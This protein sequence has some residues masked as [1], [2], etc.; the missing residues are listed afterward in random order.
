MADPIQ[1]VR[2]LERGLP[3]LLDQ[4][5]TLVSAESPSSDPD[6]VCACGEVLD[7]LVDSQLGVSAERVEVD[8]VTHL[9]WILGRPRVLL[10]GHL[11]TVW[12]H[13]TLQ[14]RPFE[15]RD[16]RL[17]G[18]GV[19]DMKAGLVQAV[20]AVAMLDDPTGIELLVTSDEEIGSP[21]S[22]ELIIEGARRA[23]AV[24]VF[25]GAAGDAVKTERKGLSRYTLRTAGRAAHAGLEPERGANALVDA[26]HQV[27]AAEALA[28]PELGTSVT[29]TLA[30]AGTASNVVPA[31]AT[32][33]IDVRAATY[34]EQLR[35]HQELCSW[36]ASL[37][38]VEL[39][40]EGEINRQPMDAVSTRELF[41]R[42]GRAAET[43]GV[44]PPPGVGVGGVSDANLAAE[45]GAPVIDGLGAVGGGAH[46]EDEH[47]IVER[48]PE[49]TALAAVLIGDLLADPVRRRPTL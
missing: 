3:E 10:V 45:A 32:V 9:R 6:A 22:R 2:E 4:V 47:V 26:A 29:P 1:L 12:P 25:E 43:I 11:D 42:V 7:S 15:R 27:L 34:E 46:A 31:S 30:T 19:F 13:G 16:D 44:T 17:L 48:I 28:R 20:T 23:E 24:L 21:T 40:V 38:G 18:P 33:E 5:G 35:V 37:P 36:V 49:R 8:G 14:R 39:T 41:G